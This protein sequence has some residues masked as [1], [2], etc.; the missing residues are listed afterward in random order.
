MSPT[1]LW[2]V[3]G[4]RV[5]AVKGSRGGCECSPVSHSIL[6]VINFVLSEMGAYPADEG[7]MCVRALVTETLPR[8]RPRNGPT[9][10]IRSER[11]P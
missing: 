2:H 4:V 3:P 8:T 10:P 7:F 5:G 9:G 11:F 6:V 1:W